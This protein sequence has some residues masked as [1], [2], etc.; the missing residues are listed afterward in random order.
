MG[1]KNSRFNNIN[2]DY[3]SV[4]N[5]FVDTDFNTQFNILT[6]EQFSKLNNKFKERK[7]L[8][9]SPIPELHLTEILP[10]ELINIIYEY[11]RE[12]L[13]VYSL[14]AGVLKK[15]TR[16]DDTFDCQELG[17]DLSS[18]CQ[19]Q[20]IYKIIR[21]PTN[22]RLIIFYPFGGFPLMAEYDLKTLQRRLLR[23]GFLQFNY[24]AIDFS[25]NLDI[26]FGVNEYG[27]WEV[28]N[29][30]DMSGF[31]LCNKVVEVQ[32]RF[33]AWQSTCQGIYLF[34]SL[35]ENK[36]FFFDYSMRKLTELTNC[37]R[38]VINVV[39]VNEST[40]I[41]IGKLSMYEYSTT[42][43][44]YV[45]LCNSIPSDQVCENDL[46]YHYDIDTLYLINSS[47]NLAYSIKSPITFNKW[48]GPH[49]N[50]PKG[51]Y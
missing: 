7:F 35:L 42:R 44:T 32:G 51:A 43:D 21:Y 48:V 41:L 33:R 20:S 36:S 28:L 27:I 26:M 40:F 47:D 45:N 11:Y 22:Q 38:D 29:Q 46:V 34:N 6:N 4:N 37:P 30:R 13:V 24:C 15:W 1:I 50:F 18:S 17:L 3:Q 16:F 49:K 23:I 12:P 9:M 31:N 14:D 25:N 39:Y 10:P 8:Y 19:N 5:E 2:N